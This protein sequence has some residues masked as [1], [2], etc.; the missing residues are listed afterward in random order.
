MSEENKEVSFEQKITH[1]KEILEKLM[2]P[3]ITLSQSV[4]FYK[5]GIKELKEATK[6]LENAKLEFEEYSKDDL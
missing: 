4:A 1:A 2:N 3:E 6:L 5:E